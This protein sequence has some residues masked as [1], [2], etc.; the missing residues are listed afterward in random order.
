MGQTK[1]F[2]VVIDAGH[3]G[4][5]PGA[6]GSSSREKDITLSV[7]KTGRI[8]RKNHKDVKVIYTRK[9]DSF[10]ALDRRAAIANN[11]KANLFISIHCNAVPKN[12]NSPQGVETF[13][14]GLHR[15]K[16]NLE[17]AKRKLRNF[18]RRGLFAKV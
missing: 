14:L 8:D 15:S 1:G 2:T 3:G 13:I 6:I 7:A 11:A 5:D 12:R 9:D 18:T 17:V 10:V 16:D 4:K